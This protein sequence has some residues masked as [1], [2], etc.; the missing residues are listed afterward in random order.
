MFS[1]GED[2]M[3]YSAGLGMVFSS[4]QVDAAVDVSDRQDIFS[5][6]GVWRF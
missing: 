4:F 2:E 5:L 1:T 6:S 3:H